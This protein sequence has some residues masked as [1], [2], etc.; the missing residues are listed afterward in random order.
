MH[1]VTATK[2]TIGLG[3][4]IHIKGNLLIP[5]DEITYATSRSGG[6]G[7]QHADKADTKVTLRFPVTES[8]TLST[9]QKRLILDNLSNRINK[10]GELLISS[11]RHRSQSANRDTVRN[12][13]AD[14]LE[15]ALTPDEPRRRTKVP[16]SSKT[17]RLRNKRKR[18]RRKEERTWAAS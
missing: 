10:E 16:R 8:T 9:E 2:E 4:D 14:L 11:Q 5:E 13:F 3:R 18:S 1:I 6:P 15:D 12:R 7:G 17:R